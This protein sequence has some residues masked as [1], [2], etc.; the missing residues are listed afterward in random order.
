[1]DELIR[2]LIE[3]RAH[4]W[5][6]AKAFLDRADENGQLSAEDNEAF[7]RAN[8][9]ISALDARIK[10]LHSTNLANREAEK[11]REDYESVIHP[12]VRAASEK[13][14]KNALVKFLSGQTDAFEVNFTGLNVVNDLK[15]GGF[16]IRNDL[17]EDT[18][19]A[20]GNTVPTSFVRSLYEHMIHA[21]AIR[22]TNVR[23]LRTSSGEALE[24]PKTVSHGT[25]ALV[26]EGTALGEVDPSFGKLTLN[27]W[28][29]GQLLDISNEM[30]SDTGV[31]IQGYIARD[32]GR[33]LGQST[34]QA[35]VVGDGSN[36]P[37]GVITAVAADA[38]TAVQIASATVELDNLIDL[39]YAVPPQYRIN[40]YW[41]MADSTAKVI[42]KKKNAD[43][44]YMWQP[45][46]VAGQPDMLFGRPVVVDPF[47][48]A[49]A[50]AAK[51]VA[52]GDFDGFIIREAGPVRIERSDQFRFSTDQVS[53]RGVMRVDSDLIDANAIDV[54]DTD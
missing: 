36:K 41:L 42:R 18:A 27:A 52:F 46:V 29:Y 23:V 2:G 49:I 35:F 54:L 53:F 47:V 33:A 51:S 4:A 25:A 1:M 34:G 26:G 17:G 31:D 48:A 32:L 22:Q 14:E 16:S 7:E 28:K 6:S 3:K 21:S 13:A 8:T 12:D 30:L 19:A 37:R 5:E 38:G 15:T 39:M 50:S 45:A 11:Y 10:E 40:G 20:G 9:E 24:L 43:G 44:D